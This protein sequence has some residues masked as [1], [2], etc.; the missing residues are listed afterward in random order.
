MAEFALPAN[1]KIGVGETYKAAAGD[2]EHP[3]VQDLSLEAGRRQEPAVDTYE[4]DLD[5]CGPM[6]LDALIKIKNEIDTLADLPP[7]LPRGHL[8]LLRDEHRRHQHAG[9]HQVDRRREGRRQDLPAA[10]HAGGAR[11]WCPTSPQPYAQLASI[12]PWLKSTT[13]AADPRAAAVA[14]RSAPSSTGCGSAS[15]ASAARPRARQLLVERRSLSRPGRPAA[16]LSLARRQPR[17]GQRASGSISWRIRSGSI[18]A[19][20]S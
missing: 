10:A 2:Q 11:T 3:E 13:P 20:R 19:T 5:A 4:V 1:S 18:A 7:L 8:R 15:C 12:E 16:G 14:S 17:R 6:V 9:L